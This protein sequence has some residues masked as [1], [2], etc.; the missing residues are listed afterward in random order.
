MADYNVWADLFRTWQST[1]DWIKAVAIVT[2]PAFAMGALALLLRYRLAAHQDL[3]RTYHLLEP[4]QHP[5]QPPEI[6]D[7]TA[8]DA[9]NDLQNRLEDARRTL[10]QQGRSLT[11][12]SQQTDPETR[13]KIEQIILEEYH[14]K[15]DPS[16]ALARLRQFL[17]DQRRSRGHRPEVGD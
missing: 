1:S 3:P 12:R 8:V 5:A 7:S 4:P 15:S 11:D 10:M 17:I 2:P 9:A 6:V 13:Q 16:D 14:R